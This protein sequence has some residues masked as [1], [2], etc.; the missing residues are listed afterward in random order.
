MDSFNVMVNGRPEQ[1]EPGGTV[2]DLLRVVSIEPD[3]RGI[4]VAVNDEVVKR[5]DW[6]QRRLADQDR[7]DVIQATQGG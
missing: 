1:I 5:A 7:V 2:E 3:R 4:A 6:N